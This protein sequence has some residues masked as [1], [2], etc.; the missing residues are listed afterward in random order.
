V[1]RR[2]KREGPEECIE[3]RACTPTTTTTTTPDGPTTTVPGGLT[4]T[5]VT[6]PPTTTSLPPC[7]ATSGTFCDRGDGTVYDSATNLVWEKKTAEPGLRSVAQL[8]GSGEAEAQALNAANFA[9]HN[10]WRMPSE[11]SCNTCYV[12]N[13]CAGCGVHELETILLPVCETSPCIDPIFGPTAEYYYW[14]R[15]P[16]PNG[17]GRWAVDFRDGNVVLGAVRCEFGGCLT[18]AHAR[19]VRNGP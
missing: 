17:L 19:S 9:G 11:T 10:D 15:T 18:S 8:Y 3:R 16:N 13:S 7:V 4:T 5:T 2:C 6:T 12:L 1:L 14:T